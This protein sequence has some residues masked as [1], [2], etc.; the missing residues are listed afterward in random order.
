MVHI[1]SEIFDKLY[2]RRKIKQQNKYK[3]EI[4]E[5]IFDT[6]QKIKAADNAFNEVDDPIIIDSVIYYQKSLISKQ[7]YLMKLTKALGIT[8][9]SMPQ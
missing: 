4:L 7:G 3:R 2:E 5:D 9:G 6:A 8:N 1:I